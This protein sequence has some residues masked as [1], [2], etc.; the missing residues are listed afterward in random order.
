MI[1]RHSVAKW[2]SSV[3]AFAAIQPM[4]IDTERTEFGWRYPALHACA[5]HHHAAARHHPPV[6]PALRVEG[7]PSKQS[8]LNVAGFLAARR[9]RQVLRA[10]GAKAAD[11]LL[12]LRSGNFVGPE[13]FS[14]APGLMRSSKHLHAGCG[15]VPS[16]RFCYFICDQVGHRHRYTCEKIRQILSVSLAD[17]L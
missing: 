12:A 5:P 9:S 10:V 11:R 6:W 4:P 3:A 8:A 13:F 2:S 17:H 1:L 15:G 16:T 7:A 14:D